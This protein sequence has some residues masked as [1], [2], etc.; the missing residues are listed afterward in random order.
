MENMKMA[1]DCYLSSP[2][3]WLRISADPTGLTAITFIDEPPKTVPQVSLSHLKEAYRQLSEYFRG[4]RLAFSLPLNPNGT[5]FQRSVWHSLTKIPFGTT[6]SYKAVAAS[7][8]CPGGARAVGMANNKNPLPIVVP[9]HRVIGVT[10]SLVG[11]A[12]G[13]AIKRRLLAIEGCELN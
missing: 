8:G 9:C 6:A 11:Y 7:I 10:G 2:V 3:G 4:E 5:D 1:E 13:I 12:S